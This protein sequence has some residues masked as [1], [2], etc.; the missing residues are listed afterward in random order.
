MLL[1]RDLVEG[2]P[3]HVDVAVL[4]QAQHL[5]IEEGQ[6][7]SADV[8]AVHVGVGEDDDLAVA[9]P[10]D[11]LSV[12]DVDADRGDQADDFI[13]AE[14]LFRAGLL[15]VEDLAAQRENGLEIAVAAALRGAAGG[16]ALDE[17]QLGLVADARGAVH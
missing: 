8:L 14:H 11:V 16:L 2:R 10:G 12:T 4:D 9:D 15:D 17:E 7:Q 1:L 3:G 13:V 6:Q 5:A